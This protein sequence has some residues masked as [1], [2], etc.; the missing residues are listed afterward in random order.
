MSRQEAVLATPEIDETTRRGG[1]G[2]TDRR[3]RRLLRCWLLESRAEFLKVVRMP[4]YAIPTILFPAM[5]YILFGLSFGAGQQAGSVSMS[6]YLLATY[7]AFGVLGAALFGFGVGV[8]IERGQGWML[9]KRASPM[10]VGVYFAAKMV[11]ALLMSIVI[12]ALL[13]GLGLAFGDVP[14]E[15]ATLAGLA[16]ML[17]IGAL[18]FCAFGL[19][20][21]IFLGPNSAPA[22]VNLIYLPMAFAS[23][24]W[25][26]LPALPE[27]FQR[28][29]PY[30]PAYHYSQLALGTI[31]ADDSRPALLHVA[32]LCVFVVLCLLG[33]AWA[34]RRDED[35][36]YG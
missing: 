20:L 1:D 15:P 23:G 10:P 18:P 35:R 5:F 9:L 25:I 24:M 2:A 21:G 32:A 26:P 6:T 4:A 36:T 8:A 22:V 33:A 17:L 28:L 13:T 14:F 34:W 29:A 19:L 31:G 3:G 16:G 30:L 7:G 11:M 12:V 27:F